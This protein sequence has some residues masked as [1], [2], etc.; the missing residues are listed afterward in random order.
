M[1]ARAFL[2]P[3]RQAVFAR[4]AFAVYPIATQTVG[5]EAVVTPANGPDHPQPYGHDLDAMA[6]AVTEQ[7]AVVFVANPNN[8][9]GTW[10]TGPELEAFL[11]QVPRRVVVVLDEAY[12]EFAGDCEGYPDGT[13]WL[14]RHPNLVITRT[15]SKAYGIAGLRVG[16]ALCRPEIADLLNRVRHPFNVSIIAQAAADAAVKATD[17]TELAIANNAAERTRLADALA[18]M[19]MRVLPSAGN[20]LCVEPG[21]EVSGINEQL[22]RRGVIV[23]PVGGYGLPSFIRVSIGLPKENDRFLAALGEIRGAGEGQG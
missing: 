13:R 12:F 7:T 2:G 8:P 17:H 1:V 6:A 10:L 11:E 21:G 15:F 4:H 9:T 19:G 16:Y 3:G 5:A 23:R 22:L 18:A 20:F 14:E